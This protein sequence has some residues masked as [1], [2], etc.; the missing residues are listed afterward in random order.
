V[1]SLQPFLVEL[2]CLQSELKHRFKVEEE[3]DEEVV[4]EEEEEAMVT[5]MLLD[6]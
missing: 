5:A 2:K 1:R 4:V 3:I 6:L